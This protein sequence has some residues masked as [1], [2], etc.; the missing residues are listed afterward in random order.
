MS[1]KCHHCGYQRP[2]G[3][4]YLGIEC[5]ICE[6]PYSDQE[7]PKIAKIKLTKS[8][9]RMSGLALFLGGI[10]TASYYFFYFDVSVA[11]PRG[12]L[13][14][15]DRINNVGLMAQRQNGIIFSFGATILGA[16]LIYLGRDSTIGINASERKCPYCAERV[17]LEAIICRHCGKELSQRT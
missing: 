5:P 8:L 1:V 6:T 16:L 3:T 15:I 11:I 2:S 17:K 9:F 12:N 13:I 4:K 7:Q 14:G 10:A